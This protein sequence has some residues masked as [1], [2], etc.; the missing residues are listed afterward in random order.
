MKNKN[1]IELLQENSFCGIGKNASCRLT[2]SN[3]PE[4]MRSK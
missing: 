4:L 1:Q 3:L 2:R